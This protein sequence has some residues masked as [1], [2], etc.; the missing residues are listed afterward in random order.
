VAGSPGGPGS[1]TGSRS[2]SS[3]QLETM[4]DQRNGPPVPAR[5]PD[6]GDASRPGEIGRAD[7]VAE[8]PG[9]ASG[10]WPPGGPAAVGMRL[11]TARPRTEGVRT[12]RS[13]AAAI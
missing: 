1:G 11:G 2:T 3:G 12:V 9:A 6:A 5:S 7:P 13:L 10:P 8:T 4:S